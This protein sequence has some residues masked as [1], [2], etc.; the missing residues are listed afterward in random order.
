MRAEPPGAT[1]RCTWGERGSYVTV[2]SASNDHIAEVMVC[3]PLGEDE[4]NETIAIASALYW[5]WWRAQDM[6]GT[7]H[8]DDDYES[9]ELAKAKTW[10]SS[11]ETGKEP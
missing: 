5:S 2:R 10:L 8:V 7:T 11:P 3:C 9:R 1:I 4:T 6:C